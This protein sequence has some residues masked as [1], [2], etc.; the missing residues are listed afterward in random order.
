M[1]KL[2]YCLRNN[3]QKR[4]LSNN[5]KRQQNRKTMIVEIFLI[6]PTNSIN[7]Y[8]IFCSLKKS[9]NRKNVD[10]SVKVKLYI[11]LYM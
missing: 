4:H 2:R 3:V 11:S 10:L 5:V 8:E 9:C 6:F 7:S 1:R